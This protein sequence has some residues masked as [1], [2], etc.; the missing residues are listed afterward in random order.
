MTHYSSWRAWPDTKRYM[1]ERSMGNYRFHCPGK[2]LKMTI[3]RAKRCFQII[4][5]TKLLL[6][7][8]LQSKGKPWMPSTT[9]STSTSASSP[10]LRSSTSPNSHKP[11][12]KKSFS[13]NWRSNHKLRTI[14]TGLRTRPH[15][16]QQ[17]QKKESKEKKDSM[18]SMD[19]RQRRRCGRSM[20]T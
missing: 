10:Q 2:R 8:H 7:R 3:E 12:K 5:I 13:F 16:R 6:Q 20:K 11:P 17:Q 4:K 18:N 15:G 14:R 1:I 9:T 19:T